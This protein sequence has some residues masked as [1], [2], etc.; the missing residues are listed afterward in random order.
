MDR[1]N[2]LKISA[3][4]VAATTLGTE[5]AVAKSR[6]KEESDSKGSY[7]VVILGDTHY[8]KDPLEVYHAGYTDP[9]PARE[10][11]H[12][13]EIARNVDMWKTRCPKILDR[14]S[15][16][17]DDKTRM[18]FQMGDMIQGDTATAEAHSRMLNDTVNFLKSHLAPLP[19]VTVVG[20]H[21]IRGN[22]DDIAAQAYRDTM[23]ARLGAE[24]GKVI[25]SNNFS[26]RIGPDAYIVID[27]NHPDDAEVERLLEEASDARYIFTILHGPVFPY[28]DK[29]YYKW[30][31]HGKDKNPA[32]RLHMREVF[33]KKNVIVLCGHTH[34]TEF[35]QWEGMG[36]RI[37]QMTMTSV[38]AKEK[39]CNF[40]PISENP[41]TYTLEGKD[42][43]FAEVR[44]GL[45]EYAH[46]DSC[47]CYKLNVS[48]SGVTV[49]FHAGGSEEV[50]KTFVLR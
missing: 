16:L 40:K 1:R 4:A 44:D 7:S 34:E 19:F 33:A 32:A 31:Y 50:T 35:Y 25:E 18:L 47:G 20:N 6:K 41:A 23:N 30:F 42:A 37:S 28:E 17:V 38:W 11:R 14:A 10:A 12:L 22:N 24:L 29:K 27:F 5:N 46:A 26:F 36:G 13:K 39:Q 21:D 2:F 49:D 3:A 15:K 9:D 48:D 43:L 8:D 45:K